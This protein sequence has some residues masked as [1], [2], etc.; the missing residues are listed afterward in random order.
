MKTVCL[1]AG[2]GDHDPG[3]VGP[4]GLCE[5]ALTLAVVRGIQDRL[6]RIV[7]VI[8]TRRS[9]VFLSLEERAAVC[10]E[11]DA[12]LFLSV[13]FNA[14]NGAATGHEVFTTAGETA[15][16]RFAEDLNYIY[17]AAFPEW[18]NRGR[19]ERDFAVL[20]KTRCPAVLYECQ[21]IDN[22]E[23]ERWLKSAANLERISDALADGI[24]RHL[25]LGAEPAAPTPNNRLLI[26]RALALLD[27]A[28]GILRPLAT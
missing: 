1:D 27:E 20:R 4:T 6:R 25:N 5:K 23:M 12:D 18:S 13:H 16:D 15:A 14:F 17:A 22:A 19:K 9:D 7:N 28:T 21:F 2:H 24:I 26:E 11:S 3:A 8:L 10:N